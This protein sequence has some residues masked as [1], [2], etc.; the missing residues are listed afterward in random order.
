MQRSTMVCRKLVRLMTRMVGLAVLLVVAVPCLAQ[1][2]KDALD[3]QTINLKGEPFRGVDL[4][5]K[6]V[7]LDFWAVWCAPCIKAFPVLSRLQKELGPLG[8]ETLGIATHSGTYEDVRNF[9]K[10]HPVDYSVAVGDEDVLDHFGVIGFPTYF[11]IDTEGNIYQQYV[12]EMRDQYEVIT[13]EVRY[14]A[15]KKNMGGSK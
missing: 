7:L 8:F 6:I 4:K 15:E 11:L 1:G 10:K 3:F 2:S 13:R 12:G 14:L 9:L 5:G